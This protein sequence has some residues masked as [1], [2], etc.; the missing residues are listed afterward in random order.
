[1]WDRICDLPMLF[2]ILEKGKKEGSWTSGDILDGQR[3]YYHLP[4]C[5]KY[6][7]QRQ[8]V[9]GNSFSQQPLRYLP[10]LGIVSCTINSDKASW[11][12]FPYPMLTKSSG[13][14]FIYLFKISTTS[15]P[16]FPSP[17]PP[18]PLSLFLRAVRVL[19][20]V[21][22]PRSSPLHPGLGR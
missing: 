16:S 12:L 17:S 13:L 22:S 8:P 2:A 18:F 7:R 19:C 4:C 15:L 6:V 5:K 3:C 20:P 1:M 21:G 11:L 10:T 9:L 14:L